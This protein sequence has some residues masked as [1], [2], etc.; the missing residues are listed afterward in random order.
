[1]SDK[2]VQAE[3]PTTTSKLRTADPITLIRNNEGWRSVYHYA[4][5]QQPRRSNYSS[6]ELKLLV[7]EAWEEEVRAKEAELGKGLSEKEKSE[8]IIDQNFL[9]RWHK[10]GKLPSLKTFS[11][12]FGDIAN[13]A[14]RAGLPGS[15]MRCY[16]V[17]KKS[18]YM[19]I[20]KAYIK[21]FQVENGYLPNRTQIR[22]AVDKGA[23]S[24]IPSSL[25][26]FGDSEAIFEKL[27]IKPHKSNSRQ[28]YTRDEVINALR[29]AHENKC[30]QIA[31]SLGKDKLSPEEKI[32]IRLT[33]VD[34]NRFRIANEGKYPHE[35]TITVKLNPY[36]DNC[37]KIARLSE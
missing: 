30:M 17:E 8:I 2:T 37:L 7:K 14:L 15:R 33:T 16:E 21:N 12:N 34:Y 20:L 29:T 19:S 18:L 13:L 5:V 22:S 10:A 11:R 1:M 32:N 6:D 3:K 25:F 31:A 27:G 4:R 23:I 35:G 9:T 24:E 36:W 26:R 28:T